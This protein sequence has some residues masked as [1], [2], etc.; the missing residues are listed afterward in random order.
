MRSFVFVSI[1]IG[2][3]V[4]SCTAGHWDW[5]AISIGTAALVLI[6]HWKLEESQP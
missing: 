3:V 4:A 6:L 2:T 5:A 1:A